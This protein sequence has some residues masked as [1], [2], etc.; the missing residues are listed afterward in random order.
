[1]EQPIRAE[2]KELMDNGQ[3]GAPPSSVSGSDDLK[4]KNSYSEIKDV[5]I[6]QFTRDTRVLPRDLTSGVMRGTQRVVND[7]GSYIT[8]GLIENTA[9][10]FG[11]AFYDRSGNLVSKSTGVTDY[12]Y[13]LDTNK[14]YYQ[15]GRLPDGSYGGVYVKTGYDVSDAIS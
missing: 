10:E 4:L 2:S 3:F 7:D 8:F 14:N 13:D 9:N 15:N 11:I 1:M 6:E 12:K 5:S